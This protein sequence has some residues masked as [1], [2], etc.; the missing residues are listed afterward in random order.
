MYP[1]V[2]SSR[3]V[4]KPGLFAG[5]SLASDAM[6]NTQSWSNLFGLRV[7]LQAQVMKEKPV[8]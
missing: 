5:D 6:E 7:L 2:A 1:F 8:E 3:F 4:D